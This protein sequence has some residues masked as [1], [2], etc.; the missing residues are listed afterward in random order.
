MYIASPGEGDATALLQ[1]AINRVHETTG[2]GIVFLA[3]GTYRLTNTV[4][5]WPSIRVIGY[6]A[7]RPVLVLPA[8]TPGFGDAS[9]EKVLCFFAGGRPGF[10]RDRRPNPATANNPVPD[11]LQAPFIPRLRTLISELRRAT[12]ALWPCARDMRNTAFWRI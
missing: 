7:Q 5:I 9:H 12:Q 1:S 8:N 10:G 4:Y 2:Q 6:G 3:E 11:A